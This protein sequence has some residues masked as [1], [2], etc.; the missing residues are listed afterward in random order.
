MRKAK[1]NHKAGAHFE[2]GGA[3]IYYEVIENAGKPTL[4]FLHGGLG[5]ISDFNSVVPMF[6]D[7]YNIVGID[8]RGHGRS[9]LG[10][11]RLTYKRL[12]LDA[13][14]IIN[15]LQ[16]DDVSV[17]GYS[18][19]GVVAYRLALSSTLKIQKIVTLGAVCNKDCAQW[20]ENFFAEVTH[21][22]YI[23]SDHFMGNFD[24]YQHHNPQPDVH[25]FIDRTL[26]MWMDRSADGYPDID[27]ETIA[28]PTLI[29]RG[30]DDLDTLEDYVEMIPKIPNSILFNVPFEAHT[31]TFEKYPQF[32]AAVVKD[33]LCI[34]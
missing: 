23:T 19:G 29:V 22:D 34:D 30:N 14:A 25:N 15:H 24:F 7:N 18:D 12:Q 5:N 28:I 1:F 16:L 10:T 20:N 6:A 26:E 11:E 8:S 32:F 31:P 3:S 27:A 13:E 33:F 4:L 9:T 21:E 17:L 2:I